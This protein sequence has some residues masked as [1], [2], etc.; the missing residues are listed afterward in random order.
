LGFDLF[1]E[2]YHISLNTNLKTI[3]ADLVQICKQTISGVCYD[4]YQHYKEL[5]E[6]VYSANILDLCKE[7]Y[8]SKDLIKFLDELSTTDADNLLE[9][10]NDWDETLIS[11]KSVID[12]VKLKTFFMR[13]SASIERIRLPETE[14]LFQDVTRCFDEIFNDNDFKNII[15]LFPTCAQSVAA[16]KHLYLELTN[17]EQ[18]KRRCIMD[19]MSHS[20]LCF[21]KNSHSER[22]FDVEIRSKNL[23]FDDL[24]ELRDRAR[25]IEYSNKHKNDQD[26]NVE[27]QQLESFVELV[28]VIETILE[29]LS[30]L[31][32]AGFPTVIDIIKKEIITCNQSQY[33]DLR[34]LHTDLKE[35]LELWENNL[36][37]MYE[38]YP[39]L[40]HFS[41]EQ[42]Q[43]VE[44]FIYNMKADEQHP[45]YHLLKYI[46]FEPA[47]L[48]RARLPQKGENENDR[49]ENVGQILRTQRSVIDELEVIEETIKTH[50]VSIK[51][52]LLFFF[53]ETTNGA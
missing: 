40:T 28:G 29:N 34:R 7:F 6:N 31:Y 47:L 21:V 45:G 43:T 8:I 22:I 52:H 5:V 50:T 4:K 37:Q 11:T 24:S 48:Q 10:V 38:I 27:I 12:F 20:V 3:F 53:I 17:K 1:L 51:C 39:E 35:K 2:R 13:A 14:L 26:H 49:L 42:F 36:C 46:G 16:I 25:L 23:T 41:C 32:I 18:S 44:S 30:S 9:A 19:I 15:G 33:D